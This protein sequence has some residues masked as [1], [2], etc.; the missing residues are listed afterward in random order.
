MIDDEAD[1]AGNRRFPVKLPIWTASF[2]PFSPWSDSIG[3]VRW[4]HLAKKSPI[5]SDSNEL[6]GHFW[7]EK[8]GR[9]ASKQTKEQTFGK[10]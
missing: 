8:K 10:R 4:G 2:L 3:I 9:K 6:P 1:A 5:L 7:A